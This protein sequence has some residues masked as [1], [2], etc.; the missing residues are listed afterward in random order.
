LG[1]A[2]HVPAPQDAS[3]AAGFFFGAVA[4]E[5]FAGAFFTA[6]VAAGAAVVAVVAAGVAVLAGVVAEA[7]SVAGVVAVVVAGTAVGVV[8]PAAAVAGVAPHP[9][10]E[11]DAFPAG[12][13]AVGA[14]TV[15]FTG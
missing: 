14:T 5:P 1:S 7:A 10:A 12:A 6:A 2:A 3:P 15:A 8:A 11:H 9:F 13:F 4:V